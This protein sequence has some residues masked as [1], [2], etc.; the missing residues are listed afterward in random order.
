[1]RRLPGLSVV[2]LPVA[3]GPG[4]PAL[5][6]PLFIGFAERGP[7]H[8]P[9][10]LEDAAQ[11]DAVFGGRFDL[12]TAEDG[13][14]L[15]AHL[16]VAVQAFF[17]GG[18]R[19]CHV[20]RVAGKGA[21][22]ARFRVPGLRLA[23]W[24]DGAWQLGAQPLRLRA[25]SPGSWADRLELSA[26]LRGQTLAADDGVAPGDVLR[27]RA[28]AGSAGGSADGAGAVGFL[29][30]D[31][32]G[33]LAEAL[34]SSRAQVLWQGPPP[35]GDGAPALAPAA[36]RLR[37]DLR[38]RRPAQPDRGLPARQWQ[39]D[40]CALS[41]TG[42]TTAADLPWTE[43]DALG[44]LDAGG[45]LLGTP[46]GTGAAA[47]AAWPLAGL[48][49]DDTGGALAEA[50]GWMLLPWDLGPAF[51]TWTPAETG[52]GDALQRNGLATV[53]AWLFVDPTW[54]PTLHGAALRA[55]AD[56]RRYFA[57]PGQRLRGLHAAFGHQ[58]EAVREASWIAVPDAVHPPWVDQPAPPRTAGWL[59]LGPEP[60]LPAAARPDA[61]ADCAPPPPCPPPTPGWTFDG[62]APG[63]PVQL[64]AGQDLRLW[65][66]PHP[67]EQPDA[68]GQRPSQTI[69]LEVQW[70]ASAD[71][72]DARP[73][74]V[75]TLPGE[76]PATSPDGGI[77]PTPPWACPVPGDLML[78]PAVGLHFLRARAWRQRLCS[79]WSV[80]PT[81]QAR[82][83][84]R[85]LLDTPPPGAGSLLATVHA[86]LIDLAAATREHVA[87]LSVPA[88]WRE[89]EVAQ[90]IALLRRQFEPLDDP[91][92]AT[93][94]AVLH[95]PWP[96][97]AL[98]R[99]ADGSPA[100]AGALPATAAGAGAPLTELHPPEG[101]VLAQ[102]AARS[103]QHGAWSAA[104]MEPLTWAV[105][106]QPPLD[107][108]RL[109]EAGANPIEPRTRGLCA[110]RAATLAGAPVG[111]DWQSLGV[112]RLFIL[113]RLLARR[114]GERYAFEPN[115]AAL[116]RSLERSFTELLDRLMQRGALRGSRASEGWRLRTARGEQLGRE[117][118]RG[119]CS[120][121][122]QVA[123][124]RPLR[125]LTL[126]LVRQGEQWQLQEGG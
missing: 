79:A 84:G 93:S 121:E 119:E 125:F 61:F 32:T 77:D 85:R 89:A 97:L 28:A 110:T 109:E 114:E 64:P 105:A 112:R 115:D 65:L 101:P 44:R 15:S 113:L 29:R 60:A 37:V 11:F 66:Q 90:H 39:R 13:Q 120:L 53:D 14:R 69:R 78:R 80:A 126:Y 48:D 31:L 68:D 49:P 67:E 4:L 72:S 16:P 103:R 6:V 59:T 116:R 83:A 76:A 25:A 118:E 9:V 38:L 122:I 23:R 54:S 42:G 108:A 12:L 123:P 86:A 43:P 55:W 27:V 36:E 45:P 26:R 73:L 51:E 100:P 46:G 20:L 17:A 98:P 41:P 63:Q 7:L 82:A 56:A 88:A 96:L 21:D 99:E 24:V 102:Y 107:A 19:R 111:D 50:G 8:R 106:L 5:D 33:T 30:V 104:G 87:L 47:T 58:D 70:A 40:R 81:L 18:G 52:P 35:A 75:G 92:Q 124:A 2:D 117:I 3:A 10:A 62:A 71:F 74:P 57:Q 1:M 22:T 94:F 34:A 95:H 91:A